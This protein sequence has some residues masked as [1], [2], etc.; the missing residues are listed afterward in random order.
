[1][2]HG[3]VYKLT[4]DGK[5]VIVVGCGQSSIPLPSVV[6]MQ[7]HCWKVKVKLSL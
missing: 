4:E 3:Y 6:H 5:V 1:V 2:V 7:T